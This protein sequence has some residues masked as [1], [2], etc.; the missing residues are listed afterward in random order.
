M[1]SI[2]KIALL[3]IHGTTLAIKGFSQIP[4]DSLAGEYYLQGV[5]ETAT[6]IL[7]K[8]DSTFEYFY[9][10][11]AVDRQGQGLWK[12]IDNQLILNSRRKPKTDYAMRT[13]VVPGDFITIK[14]IC[15]NPQILSLFDVT[16]YT[17]EGEKYGSTNSE[18]MLKMKRSK[19]NSIDLFFTLC[20][21]RYSSFPINSADNYFEFKVEPWF[22]EI[23]LDNVK[24]T[25]TDTGLTGEHPLLKGS[26][27][28]FIKAN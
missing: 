16:L 28:S 11:G 6:A 12:V 22:A 17:D 15:G 8:P 10:Y 14:I 1:V 25:I 3:A 7:L 5:M 26:D 2:Y 13:K 24:L 19:V 20:P 27:F 18:G 21:E 23:F 9:S 4:T